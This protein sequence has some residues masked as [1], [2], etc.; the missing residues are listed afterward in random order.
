M[1]IIQAISILALP[2]L[3]AITLHEVAHGLAARHYGDRTAEQLGRLSLNPLR[4]IDPVGTVIVPLVLF[5]LSG[6]I[7]GWAKPVPVDFRNLR[8]PK[9]DMA[10]V[11]LAGPMANL[12]MALI[13]AILMKL[14]MMLHAS[15][16]FIGEPL[17]YMSAVGI[18]LNLILMVLNLL[19]IPP[20]DGGRVL[21]GILPNRYSAVLD[22]VEPFGFFILLFLLL[23]GLLGYLL[24]PPLLY[25]TGL[26]ES[27]FNLPSVL[28]FVRS[29]WG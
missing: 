16:P 14:G 2:I 25:L 23:V 20:L 27:A 5:A 28:L 19:P 21:S 4:H 15:T 12:G 10:L 22:R 1:S 6:F 11:A 17:M 3:F 9:R 18:F 26:I 24:W 13:W 8:N 29:L 7:F